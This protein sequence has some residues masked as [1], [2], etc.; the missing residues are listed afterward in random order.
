MQVLLISIEHRR[1]WLYPNEFNGIVEYDDGT[2]TDWGP[3]V[4]MSMDAMKFWRR[5][6]QIT[7]TDKKDRT[8]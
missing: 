8:S 5:I 2:K 7:G 4:I 1:V 6:E 3:A